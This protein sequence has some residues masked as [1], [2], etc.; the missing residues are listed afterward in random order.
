[1]PDGFLQEFSSRKAKN[2]VM[3]KRGYY[4]ARKAPSLFVSIPVTMSILIAWAALFI[5]NVATRGMLFYPLQFI[6]NRFPQQFGILTYS[7]V[8]VDPISLLVAGYTTFIF[9]GS[10]E[11]SWLRPRYLLFLLLTNSAAALL[12]A[13]GCFLFTHTWTPIYGPWMMVASII[14]AWSVI[15]AEEE[16]RLFMA[17]PMKGKLFGWLAI[18]L[19]F[20]NTPYAYG[21][22]GGALFLGGF[23]ALGGIGTTMLFTRW[24]RRWGWIP[25]QPKQPASQPVI[26]RR[27]TII[28]RL[29]APIR[30]WKRR[31]NVAKL[32]RIWKL[33]D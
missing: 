10:L 15:N 20:F 3:G 8:A 2:T 30:E 12:W 16:V 14:F 32:R 25:R 17:I 5:I 27:V 13:V 31:R 22:Q 11:R 6:A 28:D 18:V 24:Q 33:D 4:A 9:G 26:R 1:M 19:T 7:L 23:F 21:L 29:L